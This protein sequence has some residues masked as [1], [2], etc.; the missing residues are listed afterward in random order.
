MI[1]PF[2]GLFFYSSVVET[3]VIFYPFANP[4]STPFSPFLTDSGACRLLFPRCN[5]G[6]CLLRQDGKKV[7]KKIRR[8]GGGSAFSP[9]PSAEGVEIALDALNSANLPGKRSKCRL[10]P[11]VQRS[12]VCIKSTYDRR[13][14]GSYH[15]AN[16]YE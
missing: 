15:L 4:P 11:L 16:Q 6:Y 14:S 12:R 5:Q 13:A 9:G 8:M 7:T 1:S 3:R 2:F 10:T